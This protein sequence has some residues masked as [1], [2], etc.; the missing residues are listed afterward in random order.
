L[1]K[2]ILLIL[3]GL[4]Y[5]L[6]SI[7]IVFASVQDKEVTLIYTGGTHAMLYPCDCPIEADGGV[8]RRASLIKQLRQLYPDALVLDSGNFFSGGL[9]DQNTQN[10]QLDMQR[11]IINLSSMELMKYDALAVSGDEFNFGKKFLEEAIVKAKLNFVSANLKSGKVVPYIIKEAAGI[12]VGIIGL[13][14]L[15]ARPKAQGLEFIEPKAAIR[16]SMQEL[17]KKGVS[18]VILL[19]NLGESEDLKIIEDIPGISVVIDGYN[20][21]EKAPYVK[22]GD[23]FILR[24]AKQGRRLGVAVLSIKDGKINNVSVEEKRVSDKISDDQNVLAILPRCFS[25]NDCKK[26][27]LVGACKNAGENNATCLFN[28]AAKVSLTAIVPADC[29]TCDTKP[30]VNF[31]KKQFPG[32]DVAYVNYSDKRALKLIEDLKVEVS[33]LPVYLLGKEAAKEKNFDNLKSSL[34]DRG[35]YY[36]LNPEISGVSYFLNRDRIKGKLDLFISLFEKDSLAVLNAIKEFNPN[37]HLL[38]I[39]SDDKIEAARGSSEVE[40]DE[41]AVCVQK[42]YPQSFWDYITCR[43]KNIGSS[44]WDDCALNLDVAKIKA[45]A[46]SDEGKT[47]LKENSKLAQELK[48]MFGPAYLLDNQSIFSTKGAPSNEEFKKIIKR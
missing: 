42:Y 9:L 29:Q 34:I 1:K 33:V 6:F 4:A 20:R 16:A 19:S 35:D 41:R 40:E 28:E 45:C 11:A 5:G 22:S 23:T 36:M 12:K 7:A 37:L 44:W 38:T 46:R 30:A 18:L 32:L 31:L 39:V 26:E 10:T 8:A 15:A 27:G 3:S 21:T 14:N 17:K 43:A 47:L 25:D 13:T 24:S 48:V 2:I